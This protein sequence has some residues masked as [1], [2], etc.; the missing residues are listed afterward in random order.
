MRLCKDVLEIRESLLS[1]DSPYIHTGNTVVD[2]EDFMRM[3][4]HIPA[5]ADLSEK[6]S[7]T[8]GL[9]YEN[10]SIGEYNDLIKNNET[11]GLYIFAHYSEFP[12]DNMKTVIN[13]VKINDD[14]VYNY[15]LTIGGTNTGL[16]FHKH[17][18]AWLHLLYGNKIWY[19]SKESPN[20]NSQLSMLETVAMYNLDDK[21]IQDH[22]NLIVCRQ[23]PGEI[24]YVPNNWYHG[25]VNEHNV[26]R[27]W[28]TRDKAHFT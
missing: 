9:A 17:E 11:N 15:L 26:N 16:V 19:M 3:Y 27:S 28:I 23:T 10:I 14:H 18:E 21:Y 6:I 1:K 2:F 20:T 13:D 7:Y 12:F 22:N 24:M 4:S 5:Q 8:S 25:V